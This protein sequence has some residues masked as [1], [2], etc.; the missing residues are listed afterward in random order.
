MEAARANVRLAVAYMQR[1][2]YEAAMEKLER[3]LEQDPKSSEAETTLG[4]LYE[5]LGNREEAG[6]HYRKAVQLAPEEPN[7][8]NNYGT[9]LCQDGRM[10]QAEKQFMEAIN[11]PFYGTP[12]VAYTNAGSCAM[13]DDQVAKAEQYFRRALEAN[14]RYPDALFQMASL[15]YQ[16]GDYM[17]ARAFMQRYLGVALASAESLEMAIRIE[18]ALGDDSSAREYISAL[19]ADFPD[20]PQARALEDANKNGN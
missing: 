18:R 9:W 19:R 11:S 15:K 7:V 3:A 16:Q 10:K 20:S 14:A 13:R 12:E 6:L 1:G 8:H 17:R 5:T 2:N 4:V